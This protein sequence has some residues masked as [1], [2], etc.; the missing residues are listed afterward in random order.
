MN[1]IYKEARK[2][3]KAQEF[4]AMSIRTDDLGGVA[5]YS[6]DGKFLQCFVSRLVA[7]QHMNAQCDKAR[8]FIR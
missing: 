1:T 4:T 2:C 8:K 3:Y 5:V 6:K 7:E